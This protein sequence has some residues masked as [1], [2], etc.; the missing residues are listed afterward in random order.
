MK[1]RKRE[2]TD[3]R[4][5]ITIIMV[6]FFSSCAEKNIKILDNEEL[7]SELNITVKVPK[8]I[9][10]NV[11]IYTNLNSKIVMFSD[12]HS[13][14]S[15]TSGT[16]VQICESI[17]VPNCTYKDVFENKDKPSYSDVYQRI[18]KISSA[19][20]DLIDARKNNNGITFTSSKDKALTEISYV[21]LTSTME[22]TYRL[23]IYKYSEDRVTKHTQ[24]RKFDN[25]LAKKIKLFLTGELPVEALAEE[26]RKNNFSARI[27]DS[28][29]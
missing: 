3:M 12:N 9:P 18:E 1:E 16:R 27:K 13:K 25:D 24:A 10:K 28:R 19:G 6:L 23:D 7:S 15:F 22:L 4:Y 26:L 5:I 14:M 11:I 2:I 29:W 17:S 8:I 20:L 21:E